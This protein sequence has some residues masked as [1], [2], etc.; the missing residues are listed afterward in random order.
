MKLFGTRFSEKGAAI[1][2]WIF[3]VFSAIAALYNTVLEPS[4][5]KSAF[6]IYNSFIFYF[7]ATN[8][9][10]LVANSWDEFDE[11]LEE[12]DHAK[13][14]LGTLPLYPAL[15]LTATLYIA[16]K[17]DDFIGALLSLLPI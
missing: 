7:L 5:W 3:F 17:E 2:T 13:Y 9:R 6:Y 11:M 16:I 10:L 12:T 8:A 14:V 4:Y 1:C 15:V